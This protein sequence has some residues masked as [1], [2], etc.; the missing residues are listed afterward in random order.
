MIKKQ[1]FFAIVI[2]TFFAATLNAQNVTRKSRYQLSLGTDSNI[3]ESLNNRPEDQYIRLLVTKDWIIPANRS[4]TQFKLASWGA[5]YNQ[6][7]S[8]N[9]F[10]LKVENKNSFFI[11]RNL[12]WKTW[13]RSEVK[14]F[15]K[16]QHG[17]WRLFGSTSITQKISKKTA[18]TL[19][20]FAEKYQFFKDN[21]FDL[22]RYFM[23]LSLF[24]TVSPPLVVMAEANVGRTNLPKRKAGLTPQDYFQQKNRSYGFSLGFTLQKGIFLTGNFHLE[25]E[26][27]N[28]T[29]LDYSI[30]VIDLT[31][32]YRLFPKIYFRGNFRWQRKNYLGVNGTQPIIG[33]DP[34]IGEGNNGNFDILYT[35][36]KKVSF[37]LRSNLLRQESTFRNRYYSKKV[38]EIILEL[39]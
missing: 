29:G 10:F 9:K 25:K 14:K 36:S 24:Y 3:L 7:S 35:M 5:I 21:E 27:S 32:V 8:E 4:K 19:S 38:F 2:L 16:I 23:T 31:T 37:I 18:Y 26:N 15:I 12:I 6:N 33:I 17:F 34:E 20:C 22:N 39:K 30:G 28:F 1:I 13:G 11:K